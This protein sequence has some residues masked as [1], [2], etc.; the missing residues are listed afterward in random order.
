MCTLLSFALFFLDGTPHQFLLPWL[1]VFIVA[2][3][4][5]VDAKDGLGL[6]RDTSKGSRM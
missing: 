2:F 4:T 6:S 3:Y 5:N 1:I